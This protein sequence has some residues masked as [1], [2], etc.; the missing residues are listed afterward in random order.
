MAKS[1]G[2]KDFG[3][4]FAGVCLLVAAVGW[5]KGS[6][7]WPWWLGGSAAFAVAGLVAPRLLT[8]LSR[9]WAAFGDALHKIMSPLIMGVLFFCVVTPVGLLMRA[10]GKDPLRLRLDPA[11][12]DYWLPRRPPGPAPETIRR[13]F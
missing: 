6:G 12:P 9:G 13:Q 8:P 2:E 10:C 1:G 11:A 5:W 4:T 3:L 7:A